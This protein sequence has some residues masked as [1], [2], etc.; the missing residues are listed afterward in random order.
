MPGKNI[1]NRELQTWLLEDEYAQVDIEC[2]EQLELR[3]ELKDKPDELKRHSAKLSNMN[4]SVN[5][6]T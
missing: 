1:Q 3:E 5:Y 6:S 2:Q 4:M